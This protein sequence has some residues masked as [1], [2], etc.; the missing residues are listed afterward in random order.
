M[1]DNEIA[2]EF[3]CSLSHGG[4]S[5]GAWR[6]SAVVVKSDKTQLRFY[7]GPSESFSIRKINQ[8]KQTTN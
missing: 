7:E 3:M 6:L 4:D 1:W 2:V 8:I 5:G